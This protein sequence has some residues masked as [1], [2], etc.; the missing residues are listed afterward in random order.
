[1]KKIRLRWNGI[2]QGACSG[3]EEE[4]EEGFLFGDGDECSGDVDPDPD[5]DPDDSEDRMDRS[6]LLAVVEAARN[7]TLPPVP[8]GWKQTID[9]YTDEVFYTNSING[10]RVIHL[11][12][13]LNEFKDIN[14]KCLLFEVFFEV[15]CYFMFIKFNCITFN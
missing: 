12:H 4:E 3:E 5:P 15:L 9:P 13:I 14:Y 1:M 6:R 8:K 10:A 2:V 11:H 7:R